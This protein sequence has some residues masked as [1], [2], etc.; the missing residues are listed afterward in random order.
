MVLLQKIPAG[1]A[2]FSKVAKVEVSREAVREQ[3][4]G[5][6]Q[7]EKLKCKSRKS[8]EAFA[9]QLQVVNEGAEHAEQQYANGP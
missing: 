9:S 1:P 3:E 5:K 6:S 2:D 4:K 8:A 7:N